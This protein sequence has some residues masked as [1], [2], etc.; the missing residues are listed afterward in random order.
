MRPA[1]D[2]KPSNVLLQSNA[3]SLT[4]NGGGGRVLAGLSGGAA[5][6]A[7]LA[8]AERERDARGYTAKVADF[9]MASK[10][11][12]RHRGWKMEGLGA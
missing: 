4:L 3:A 12:V 2:L 8:A 5:A 10:V 1:G 7:A 6:A 9:G 11:E